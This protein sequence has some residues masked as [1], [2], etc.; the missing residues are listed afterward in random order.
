M[1]DL[2]LDINGDLAIEGG[3]LVIVSG[4]ECLAQYLRTRLRLFA[5]EWFLDTRLGV[6][7]FEQ[8]L[9][10]SPD[11]SLI[12]TGI[13]AVVLETP[14]VLALT[15]FEMTHD[16]AARTLTVSFTVS[17]D[18]GELSLENEELTP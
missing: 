3:D 12:E 9:V 5:G 17:T 2:K 13:K 6:P 15:A 18:D 8:I 16:R 7:Y 10:K 1:R 14:G 4:A 11:L